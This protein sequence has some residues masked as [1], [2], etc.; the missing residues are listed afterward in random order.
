VVAGFSLRDRFGINPE[1]NAFLDKS[2]V[3]LPGIAR[4]HDQPGGQGRLWSVMHS[5]GAGPAHF[6][7]KR[8]GKSNGG[9]VGI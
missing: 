7:L 1:F 4:R 5:R 3:G 9:G 6:T 8:S 2:A